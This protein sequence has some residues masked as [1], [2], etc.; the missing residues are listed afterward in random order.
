MKDVLGIIGG[1]GPQASAYFYDM[2]TNMTKA[3]KDQDHINIIL[4]SHSTIPDRT[5]YILDNSKENPY[6]Y[7]LEDVKTLEKM[8]AK[9]IFIPCNT[10]CYF[11]EQLQANTTSIVNNMIDDTILNLKERNITKVAIMATDGTISSNLYQDSCKKYNIEYEM[12]SQEVQKTIMSIIYDKVKKG[13]KVDE[14]TWNKVIET[15]ESKY[16]ILGCTELSYLKRMLDLD[17]NFID[18]LE[19][20]A[21]KIIHFFGKEINE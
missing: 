2:I 12:P 1:L 16:I 3:D 6:P 18:P 20:Q 14:K 10:S 7:L 9:M 15:F 5:E 13:I 8:G 21:R 11:H 17:N 4:L 19:V